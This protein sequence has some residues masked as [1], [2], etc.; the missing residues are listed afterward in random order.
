M[1]SYLL[2]RNN[3]ETGPHS[4]DELVEMG[5]KPYDLIWVSGKSAAWRY[6]GEIPELAAFAPAAEEQPFDRFFKKEQSGN[7]VSN[8]GNATQG[9]PA[10]KGRVFVTL[11]G[12]GGQQVSGQKSA[13][14]AASQPDYSEY[15]RYQ[16]GAQQAAAITVTENPVAAA[17]RQFT[18]HNEADRIADQYAQTLRERKARLANRALV[19]SWM[20]KAAV[21]LMIAGVGGLGGW[22]LRKSDSKT[23]EPA[24]I[25]MAPSQ[26]VTIQQQQQSPSGA[27][28]PT[29]TG[30]PLAVHQQVIQQSADKHLPASFAPIH[31]EQQ[32]ILSTPAHVTSASP[33]KTPVDNAVPAADMVAQGVSVNSLTG[34]RTKATRTDKSDGKQNDTEVVAPG[35]LN[36]SNE[37]ASGGNTINTSALS[38]QVSVSNNA[39]KVV[40]L[41]GIRGLELTVTNDSKYLLDDVIVEVDYLRLNEDAVKTQSLSFKAVA[42]GSSA[43]IR[44]PDTNRGV[45]IRYR[46]AH[47]LCTQYAKDMAGL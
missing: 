6:A 27:I 45:K 39:Y 16:P 46:V 15:E 34:A 31:K 5:L 26:P 14:K 25:A 22:M 3:K 18:D 2:L 23:T 12:K 33:I 35:K 10:A 4:L 13:E 29:V 30:E 21:V 43:T 41:G 1:T 19:L 9:L 44:V 17:N 47:I 36:G 32:E 28:E 7:V 37:T 40:A 20:R 24:V 38:R 8:P 11:P 42:P